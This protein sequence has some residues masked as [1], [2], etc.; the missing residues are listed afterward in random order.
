MAG[1][2]GWTTLPGKIQVGDRHVSAR[3]EKATGWLHINLPVAGGWHVAI[4]AADGALMAEG[5]GRTQD[6]AYRQA[7]TD[8]QGVTVG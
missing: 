7:L 8:L 4:R 3:Y 1:T 2:N 5:H 6:D